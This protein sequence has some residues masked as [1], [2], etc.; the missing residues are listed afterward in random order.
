MDGELFVIGRKKDLII[1]AGENIYPRDIEEIA[2]AHVAI[3]EGM[4]VAFG[5][6][7]ASL[8]SEETVVVAEVRESGDLENAQAIEREVR[9]AI[10][11]ELGASIAPYSSSRL[12]GS[13]RARPG[14]PA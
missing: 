14:K 1:V 11:A 7:N 9:S 3:C 8:G 2:S 12:G 13:G 6:Y 4:V 5:H 10:T